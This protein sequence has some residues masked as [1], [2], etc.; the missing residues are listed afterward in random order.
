ML[1]VGLLV[2]EALSDLANYPLPFSLPVPFSVLV[3]TGGGL[4]LVVPY[5]IYQL[6]HWRLYRQAPLT[7][8]KLTGYLALL[9]TAVC[10]GSGVVLTIQA[11][12]S[13]RISWGVAGV[14][15]V[16]S[17]LVGLWSVADPGAADGRAGGKLTLSRV[18]RGV[19]KGSRDP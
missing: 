9:V 16:S 5:I 19:L 15:I 8:V 14:T 11:A 3:H 2:F 12:L 13:T 7:H 10:G 18:I 1:V 6:R 17:L 4:L